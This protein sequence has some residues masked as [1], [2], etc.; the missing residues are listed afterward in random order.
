MNMTIKKGWITRLHSQ[1]FRFDRAD[2]G[3]FSE[4]IWLGGFESGQ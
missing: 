3:Q 4:I 1:V 2:P